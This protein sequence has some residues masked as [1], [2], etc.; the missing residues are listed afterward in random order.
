MA[1]YYTVIATL[2]LIAASCSG[3]ALREPAYPEPLPKQSA[4]EL[5][6]RA[7]GHLGEPYRYGGL[8]ARGWDCSGFV[9]MMY[10]KS[11]DIELPRT[12]RDMYLGA[13]PVPLS[14]GKAGDLVFFNINARKPSQVGIY[15]G[16]EQFIH[17]SKAEG[18]VVSSLMENY[19]ARHFIGLRRIPVARAN[20]DR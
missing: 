1:R 17:V 6:Q 12:A 9:R 3:P 10:K 19:Y 7:H 16:H 14:R 18:V 5:V 8:S 4:G 2:V 15:L 11:L 20:S 13:F